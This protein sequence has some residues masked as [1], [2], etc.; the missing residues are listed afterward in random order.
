[1][2]VLAALLPRAHRAIRD[3]DVWGPWARGED[4]DLGRNYT[5]VRVTRENAQA[6]AAVWACRNLIAGTIASLPWDVMIRRGGTRRPFRPRPAWVGTPNVEQTHMEFLE[7][8][9]ESLL[10]DGTAYVY[11]P[12]GSD[13]RVTETWC[14]HPHHVRPRRE[15]GQVV[16]DVWDDAGQI[17]LRGG[18]GG[19]MFHIPAYAPPGALRGMP[20]LEVA[21]TM[22][23]GGL[24]AQEF[25]ARFWGQGMSA[26]GII[27]VPA[28]VDMS[29]EQREELREDFRRIFHGLRRAHLP[30]VLTGGATWQPLTITPE[31]AQFIESRKFTKADIATFFMVPPHL[32]SDV[33]R[34]TSWGTG[35]EEQAISFVTYTLRQWIVRIEQ[36]F[37]KYLLFDLPGTFL[38]MNVEGLL[39]GQLE[40]RFRAYATGR[41][42]GWLSADEI[43]ALEDM[44]P[45]GG[46]AG[47]GYLSP[48]NMQILTGPGGT[49]Q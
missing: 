46:D 49:E 22:I 38:R 37:T 10:L 3:E 31:Q 5:P 40:N 45:I 19:R 23:G 21:R 26:S 20:P 1:M 13:G 44:P 17:T 15:D 33:E 39:R 34:S 24:A 7:Q 4:I 47:E 35:I 16:Y 2:S 14:V 12:R 41:Q 36:S 6:L 9:V 18:L 28:G 29:R 11:T 27:Q 8:V 30:A 43:R 25:A 42:W 32:I 48:A